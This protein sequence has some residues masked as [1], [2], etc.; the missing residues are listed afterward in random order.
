M[1]APATWRR[2]ESCGEEPAPLRLVWD[3]AIERTATSLFEEFRVREQPET[4]RS[5]FEVAGPALLPLVRMKVRRQRGR[6][7][8]A[9]LL[10]DTFA[11][12]YRHRHTF[13]DRGPGSFVRW[14]LA[15]ADN[16]IRQETRETTRRTR[17]EQ[18]VARSI[19][20]RGADPIVHL[21]ADEARLVARITYG[22]LRA[23]VLEGMR[24]LPARQEQVLL[25]HAQER[26]N[27]REIARRLGLTHG[28]VSMRI[29]RARLT[30]LEHVRRRLA[31][32]PQEIPA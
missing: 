7:D 19:E 11:Q 21:L 5:L 27:Y 6:V 32:A 9:E 4:F 16:L 25:L 20:D 23:L 14:F 22:Q 8:P 24:R 26:L 3:G 1:G 30:I 15:I 2:V 17:R 29:R 12:I 28:A 18:L 10:T 31:P 13:Q